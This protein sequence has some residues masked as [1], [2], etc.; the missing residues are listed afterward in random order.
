M[1]SWQCKQFALKQRNFFMLSLGVVLFYFNIDI[2][3]WCH[4]V[5]TSFSSWFGLVDLSFM[6]QHTIAY[7][8][9]TLTSR[10]YFPRSLAWIIVFVFS[11]SWK[12][13]SY[14]VFFCLNAGLARDWIYIHI[15]VYS[16][17]RIPILHLRLFVITELLNKR[18]YS[19]FCLVED[20]IYNFRL[21][22]WQ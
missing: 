7:T 11:F 18:Q 8:V 17:F 12:Y 16:E 4:Y 1:L 22:D 13:L 2:F 14:Y 21:F 3:R 15:Y 5:Y 20:G 9:R 10:T 6:S 19:M